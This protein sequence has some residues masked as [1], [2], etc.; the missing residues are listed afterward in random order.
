MAYR[1]I[2]AA[3]ELA[4]RRWLSPRLKCLSHPARDRGR[5]QGPGRKGEE[6]GASERASERASEP[7][8]EGGERARRRAG[9]L[10]SRAQGSPLLSRPP[11]P[12]LRAA[13]PLT[14]APGEPGGRPSPP[15]AAIAPPGAAKGG[16]GGEASA[17]TPGL[18]APQPHV[19][20]S[21]ARPPL[22]SSRARVALG[23]GS[24]HLGSWGSG[25]QACWG[26]PSSAG[27]TRNCGRR[28][29]HPGTPARGLAPAPWDPATRGK[30][31]T[32]KHVHSLRRGPGLPPPGG[33]EADSGVFWNG[34]TSP[35]RSLFYQNLGSPGVPP[36]CVR[37][38]RAENG[39]P[40]RR[41]AA[42]VWVLGLPPRS[43]C[44]HLPGRGLAGRG[45]YVLFV[46]SAGIPLISPCTRGLISPEVGGEFVKQTV[47][48]PHPRDE[49]TVPV[50]VGWGLQRG[51]RG[52]RSLTNQTCRRTDIC[53][54]RQVPVWVRG[55]PKPT[56]LAFGGGSELGPPCLDGRKS[57]G[58]CSFTLPEWRASSSGKERREGWFRGLAG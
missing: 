36:E 9:A 39:D 58:E 29:E 37:E 1:E 26:A 28:P 20:P 27:P 12:F 14:A 47:I 30:T 40:D 21:S 19:E 45:R 41:S 18:R 49:V 11:P 56:F 6:E 51:W 3:P 52:G 22:K 25:A 13:Y 48:R 10:A 53:Y 42:R 17:E 34:F 4:R 33:G 38:C 57:W 46:F 16:S 32:R 8:Q 50:Q 15:R 55:V 44:P 43:R 23:A 54:R 31:R 5:R 2:A 24:R 7:G 35:F